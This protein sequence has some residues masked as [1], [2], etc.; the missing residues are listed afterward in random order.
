MEKDIGRLIRG[1]TSPLMIHSNNMMHL[2]DRI[3]NLAY[4]RQLLLHD[5]STLIVG[6]GASFGRLEQSEERQSEFNIMFLHVRQ[7]HDLLPLTEQAFEELTFPRILK[8]KKKGA[9][10]SEPAAHAT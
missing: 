10:R 2:G 5:S 3:T 8:T 9:V 7:S 4:S 6:V 1:L